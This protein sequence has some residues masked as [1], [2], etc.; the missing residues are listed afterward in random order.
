MYMYM[1]MCTCTLHTTSSVLFEVKKQQIHKLVAITHLKDI[2]KSIST[3][4]SYT[5]MYMYATS[6]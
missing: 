1:Y 5:Y 4:I 6:F 2:P 3:V